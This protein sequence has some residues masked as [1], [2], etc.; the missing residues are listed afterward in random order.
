MG[1]NTV[2]SPAE[3]LKVFISYARSD[4]AALAED[5]VT[6]LELSG[7]APFLDR[8]DIA[9]AEDWEARLGALIQSADTIVFII[10]P[11]A[12]KSE[13]CAW[14]VDCAAKFGKRLIP[15]RLIPIQGDPVA[16]ADV[17]E[18]LRR[19]NYVFFREGQSSLKPIAELATAL[20]QDV[21]WIREHTRLTE[22]AVRWE[23]RR[24][25]GGAADDLLLRGDDLKEVAAWAA[26]RKENAPEIT[27]LQRSYLAA[28]E[29]YATS[30]ADA[31]RKRLEER[32]R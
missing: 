30:L 12:I 20:R 2:E 1:A 10:S 6:G 31:E 21:E 9:A 4:G 13:R 18:R 25:V 28:S 29:S 7:F 5:L 32:E 24:Q 8:H 27:A 19:L 22:I 15:V 16:E 3:R 11:A 17:P 26:R 23:A 14:E